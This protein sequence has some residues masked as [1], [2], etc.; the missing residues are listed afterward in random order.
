MLLFNYLTN[1]LKY[2]HNAASAVIL[3]LKILF[4]KGNT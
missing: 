2:N 4:T 3:S 1:P